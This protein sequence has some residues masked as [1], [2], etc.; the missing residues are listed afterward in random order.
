VSRFYA[1]P[2]G[3]RLHM[4]VY[5]EDRRKRAPVVCLPGLARTADDFDA[6]ARRLQSRRRVFAFDYRGRGLSDRD[7]DWRR[8]S[9]PVELADVEAGLAAAGLEG[10]LFVGTSRGGLHIM[11][12][13]AQ[14]PGII[15]AAVLND[16][17]PVI[18][19]AGIDRI[20]GYVGK[21]KAPRTWSEA[22]A[23]FSD[24]LKDQF[25]ALTPAEVETYARLTL[26]ER[27]GE[28][29]PRYDVN[30]M[31]GL[32]HLETPLPELW[33]AFDALR[34]APLLVIRGENSDL[35]S[36]R[37][38]EAMAARHP[39][40]ETYVAPGQGHAPLLLDEASI[41]RIERFL[42]AADGA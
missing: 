9:L 27:D 18:E 25:P 30:L 38:L 2:D 15:R 41:A 34:P 13:A 36:P 35:L 22:I 4:R 12:L 20:R 37:T 5:G 17:G 26:E 28:L 32:A 24:L 8:Y 42:D 11:G 31:W 7:P 6:L 14:R 23:L 21:L 29:V 3:L 33:D 1:A 39:R 16:I 40:C 10:A 19:T